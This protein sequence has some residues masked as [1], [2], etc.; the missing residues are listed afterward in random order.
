M[1]DEKN[2]FAFRPE[3]SHDPEKLLG[4]GRRERRSWLVQNEKLQVRREGTRNLD[5][6]QLG[7]R[8]RCDQSAGI[9]RD[10]EFAQGTS[11][12]GIHSATIDNADRVSWVVAHE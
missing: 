2:R 8:E 5:E 9:E 11:R 7:H 4:F 6:L 10:A 12:I 1:G 3:R